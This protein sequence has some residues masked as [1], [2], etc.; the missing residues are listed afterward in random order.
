MRLL[1]ARS[2]STKRGGRQGELTQG[3]PYGCVGVMIGGAF[4]TNL[5]RKTSLAS[6]ASPFVYS[7]AIA[8]EEHPIPMLRKPV[9]QLECSQYATPY[10]P[11]LVTS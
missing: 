9:A 10:E 1:A 4:V 6:L 5:G 7:S 11:R 2:A 3:P 8:G